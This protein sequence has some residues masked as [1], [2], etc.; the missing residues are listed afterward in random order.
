M[1]FHHFILSCLVTK[2][3]QR[4]ALTWKCSNKSGLKRFIRYLLRNLKLTVQRHTSID[5]VCM[6]VTNWLNS[7]IEKL[8]SKFHSQFT[9]WKVVHF[10]QQQLEHLISIQSD[11]S[12]GHG[13]QKHNLIA[14][15]M[16]KELNKIGFNFIY[17]FSNLHSS[18][19]KL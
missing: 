19:G 3:L 12:I 13:A 6:Y 1:E 4:P 14:I 7:T 15:E 11:H 17:Y 10:I 5:Y 8:T 16:V 18:N 9:K 2:G